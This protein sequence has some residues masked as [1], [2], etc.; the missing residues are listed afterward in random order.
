MKTDDAARWPEHDDFDDPWMRR[1]D[2]DPPDNTW[3][4]ALL[5][6]VC[7]ALALAAVLAA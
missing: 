7:G 3:L 4:L 2:R 5:A 6:G 1:F